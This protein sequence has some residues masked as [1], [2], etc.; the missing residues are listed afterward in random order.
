MRIRIV[1]AGSIGLLLAGKLA[2]AKAA[3]IEL[4]TRTE[5]Q[6]AQ[7]R[8]YGV[9]VQQEDTSPLTARVRVNS[10]ERSSFITERPDWL[11]LTVKRQALDP[12]M[13]RSLQALAP[14]REGFVCWQNGIGHIELLE[15]A[16][17]VRFSPLYA[18]VTT[19]GAR[20]LEPAAVAHTG[21]GTTAI[22]KLAAASSA[23]SQGNAEKKLIEA[24]ISA[25]F[26]AAMSKH[27]LVDVWNKLL[28]NAA[29]NPLT[30]VLRLS[31]GSLLQSEASRTVM[32]KLAAEAVLVAKAEG[33]SPPDDILEKIADVC[34]KTARNRSSMLQDL[35]NGR[36]TEN[37]WISGSIVRLAE[38]HRVSVPVTETVYRLIQAMEKKE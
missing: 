16:G 30:A 5:D 32:D 31:N 38:K 27:I 33:I 7:V 22:G 25:G 4:I 35:D 10:M 8:E 15:E 12:D 24:L 19:E 21:K 28:I 17:F 2:G 14:P 13:V 37:E 3:E 20:R 26:A 11:F 34:R 29:I 36:L 18:A 9:T 23:S 1:G 6:A